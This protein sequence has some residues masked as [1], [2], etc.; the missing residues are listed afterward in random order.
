M[1]TGWGGA[2]STEGR[3]RRYE[4]P[5]KWTEIPPEIEAL[6]AKARAAGLWN[7]FLPRHADSGG[8]CVPLPQN[9]RPC[10]CPLC[11]RQRRGLVAVVGARGSRTWSMRRLPRRRDGH[12]SRQR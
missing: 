8:L 5:A 11:G 4:S 7:M 3:E 2:A 9:K 6:K 1:V 10:V 12:S